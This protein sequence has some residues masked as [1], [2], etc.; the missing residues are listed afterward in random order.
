MAPRLVCHRID[1]CL[2]CLSC[3]ARTDTT[4]ISLLPSC[5][6]LEWTCAADGDYYA[7][8]HGYDNTQQGAF[9]LQIVDQG[10]AGVDPCTGTMVLT[11]EAAS[12]SFMDSNYQD[13]ELCQWQ[14]Q[15]PPT[16]D[17]SQS[18]VSI[19]FERFETELDY[20]E[21][22]IYDGDNN[23][24]QL[25][26]L[27]SG[28]MDQLSQTSFTSTS[29]ALLLEFMSDESQ[30]GPGFEASYTCG[31]AD[32]C[33]F[34][35]VVQCG[36]HGQ[37]NSGACICLDGY[38][39]THC[40]IHP[41]QCEFPLHVD[42]GHHGTCAAGQCTCTDGYTGSRC[43]VRPDPCTYPTPLDCGR[44]GVCAVEGTGIA[45]CNCDDG[46]EGDACEGS[47]DP[48]FLTADGTP[49][50][51]TIRAGESRRF[52]LHAEEAGE[53]RIATHLFGLPDTVMHLYA[54]DGT[55][56]LAENDD[57]SDGRNSE[58]EWTC[59]HV[60]TYFIVVHGYAPEQQGQ[61]TITASQ[62]LVGALTDPC[63]NTVTS[64]ARAAVISFMPSTARGQTYPDDALC[65][66]SIDCGA[67]P[68]HLVFNQLDTEQDYDFVN[69]FDS[70]GADY[71]YEL[72]ELSGQIV[73]LAAPTMTE[74]VS[75]NGVMAIEFTSDESMG[76][77]GFEAEYICGNGVTRD[78]EIDV[79]HVTTDG[80]PITVNIDTPG[81]QIWFEFAGT[82]GNTYQ[83]GTELLG[84][85]DTVMHLYDADAETEIAENDDNGAERSS[86]LEWTCPADG[87]YRVLVHGY[88]ISQTGDFRFAVEQVAVTGGAG[89]PC[90]TIANLN[91]N[92]AVINFI[93]NPEYYEDSLCD[94]RIQCTQGP[95]T[96]TFDQFDTERDYDFV[97]LYTCTTA[98]C[99][100]RGG[101][102]AS[103]PTMTLLDEVSGRMADMPTTTFTTDPSVSTLL[104]EFSS[105][106]SIN[107]DGFEASYT[108]G[109]A[110]TGRV[111]TP[112]V[113]GVD[114][115]GTITANGEQAWFSFDA[116]ANSDY[117][118]AV[119]LG[120]LQ[121]SVLH[122]YAPDGERQLAENDDAGGS[123]M[124]YLE[125][126]APSDGTYYIMVHSYDPN[127]VGS[128][129]VQV[130]AGGDGDPCVAGAMMAQANADIRYMPVGGSEADALCEWSITC[131]MQTGTIAITFTALDTEASYD[132]VSLYDGLDD[133]AP[134]LAELSGHLQ[135]QPSISFVST[136]TAMLIKYESDETIGGAGFEASYSCGAADACLHPAPV[137]CGQHGVCDSGSGQ[138]VCNCLDGYTNG[139]LNRCEVQPDPCAVVDC[140]RYGTC[141]NGFCAC[142]QNDGYSGALCEVPPN[143]CT[144]QPGVGFNTVDCGPHGQCDDAP[145][146]STNGQCTCSD[147]YMGA[148]C[149]VAPDLCTV[150]GRT[151]AGLALFDCG[152]NGACFSERDAA[153]TCICQN[154]YTGPTCN[155]PPD[156]CSWP[157][158]IVC[159][160]HGFC[161]DGLCVC[162]NRYNG[163]RCETPPGATLLV[164]GVPSEV[165]IDAGGEKVHFEFDGV[166]GQTY[167]LMT[168]LAGLPDT[169]MTLYDIVPST[170]ALLENDDTDV[171][172]ESYLAWTCP[173]TGR[174]S[175]QVRA[176]DDTQTGGFRMLYRELDGNDPCLDI[177]GVTMSQQTNGIISF[178]DSNYADDSLCEWTIDCGD[179]T[180]QIQFTEFQTEDKYDMVTLYDGMDASAP[181]LHQLMGTMT[182][183]DQAGYSTS[184]G[185]HVMM[186]EF[187]SDES[188]S[189]PG[190]EAIY[191][192]SAGVGR[193][194]TQALSDGTVAS[195]S[196]ISTS[197]QEWF[198]FAGTM[199]ET[200]VISAVV[201][202]A[203]ADTEA[204]MHLYDTDG[205]TQ[206]A[207]NDEASLQGFATAGS[208]EWT[209]PA[210][211]SYPV[212]LRAH[213]ELLATGQLQLTVAPATGGDP[214]QD[215]GGA[216][217]TQSAGVISFIGDGD[218]QADALCEWTITCGVGFSHVS[219]LFSRVETEED[220]D[221]VAVYEGPLQSDAAELSRLSGHNIPPTTVET[222]GRTALIQFTSDEDVMDLGFE[223]SFDCIR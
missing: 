35:A 131:P 123:P 56:E 68:V 174:Y 137:Q 121:D 182:A 129:N 60:G 2:L 65:T 98:S 45:F 190:F 72:A 66:W 176:Y 87:M 165:S 177:G 115:P 156:Q 61:F 101:D 187:T 103:D 52:R 175:V 111:A 196:I 58:I 105:D 49:L 47:A 151:A 83:I 202:G 15:C 14:V 138:A 8:V 208:L 46:W 3:A 97:S 214:C 195:V 139:A 205:V 70:A 63:T 75:T 11:R 222:T 218:Y 55:T 158:P 74:F 200:Y 199:G 6:Y 31:Q 223:V 144:F 135:D 86:Y 133:T 149:D 201:G 94:W 44:H 108:C 126:H 113:M 21:V 118:I 217:L 62:A 181:Q 23:G 85:A 48:P 26:G 211:G 93:G 189:G 29:S 32:L 28:R 76:A 185:N 51:A 16:A 90:A 161:A 215:I 203:G 159:G 209:C 38:T 166:A 82:A 67:D 212:L 167:E 107:G 154:G 40:E 210:T 71:S 163:A 125:W 78:D 59:P 192:C 134:V 169:V 173:Q 20:D 140:G 112:V 69:V 5:R 104:L 119:T 18:L 99:D 170:T 79:T 42:C 155:I 141:S 7:A 33:L 88:D 117:G 57:S 12:I 128:F 172:R 160:S 43:D 198:Q 193:T 194:F 30:A 64:T 147:G 73:D 100:P 148:A 36:D 157:T 130:I 183:S 204:V 171:G 150:A 53:Y 197:Q 50:T 89:D 220:Y 114:T 22:A 77:A 168:E 34:P 186:V 164:S 4:G 132:T 106:E 13:D 191:T 180:V 25:L 179:G 162:T 9:A 17:G 81:Q 136:T 120:S 102:P 27:L 184:A 84:L 146:S 109:G 80:T 1:D 206:L 110:V 116:V 178:S 213:D 142:S 221:E 37:C 124:S 152:A 188:I 10:G 39:G 91:I 143:L 127:G 24:A 219:L 207:E 145:S 41:D 54:P 92:G 95:I 216:T 153:P 19:S 96:V 122:L